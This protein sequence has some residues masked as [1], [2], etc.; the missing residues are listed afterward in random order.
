MTSALFHLDVTGV[1]VGQ[2]LLDLVDP[3]TFKLIMNLLVFT[4]AIAL[5]IP[6]ITGVLLHQEPAPQ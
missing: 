3:D 2:K 1:P 4:S 5:L 6:G